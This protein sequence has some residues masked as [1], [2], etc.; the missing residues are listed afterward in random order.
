MAILTAA[1]IRTAVPTLADPAK[2]ADAMLEDLV[3][4]F[5]DVAERYRGVAYEPRYERE[6]FLPIH[7]AS[8]LSLRWAKVRSIASVVTT[9]ND[10]N[11]TTLDSTSYLLDPN[12][13]AVVLNT[14]A[15]DVWVTVTYQHGLGYRQV[16][17]GVTASSDATITSATASFTVE[18]IGQAI[19]GTGIPAR[20]TIV[21]I[22]STTSVEI[23]ANATATGTD[24]TMN[25]GGPP[26][27]LLRACRE[28]VRS[29]ALSD[30]S[31]VPRDVIAQSFGDGGYTR[32]STPDWDA[33]RPTGYL[34]VDRLLNSL[35]D[36]RFGFA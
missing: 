2:F 6:S 26:A 20:S 7:P 21:S 10:G 28:Y 19:T 36:F 18:D 16:T 8:A 31:K 25:I 30:Q 1:E 33:G 24:V 29:C 13:S 3:A 35:D 12:A 17:D 5:T 9:D 4:E 15:P 11:S 14:F 32:Y 27:V 23:S 34:E 22:N